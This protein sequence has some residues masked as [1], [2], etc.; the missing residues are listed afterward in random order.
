MHLAEPLLGPDG[1]LV[2]GVGTTLGE[3]VVR[4][5]RRL[6][7]ESVVVREADEVADWEEAKD[8]DAALAALEARF[9]GEPADAILSTLKAALARHLRT[10]AARR[11]DQAP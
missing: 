10:R 7:I 8:L 5:L 2:A 3:T 6:G 9:A 11:E 4:S 1:T